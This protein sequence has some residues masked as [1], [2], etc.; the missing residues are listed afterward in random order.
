[1]PTTRPRHSVTET[2]DVARALDAAAREW[3]ELRDDRAALLRRL[4]ERGFES[5][6]ASG[7]EELTR[8]RAALASLTGSMTAQFPADYREG[9]RREWPE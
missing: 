9:L 6:T 8:R 4:I 3:P 1:M 5:L 7:A 2:D